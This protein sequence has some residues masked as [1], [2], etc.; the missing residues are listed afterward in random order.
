LEHCSVQ[1]LVFLQ[2]SPLVGPT[3]SPT[4]TLS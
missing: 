2:E 3:S 4:L 1:P